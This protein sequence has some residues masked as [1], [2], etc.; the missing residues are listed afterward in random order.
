MKIMRVYSGADGQSHFDEIE[1]EI[2][3]LQPAEAHHSAT[4]RPTIST[5]GIGPPVASISS[6]YQ[7]K[8]RSRSVMAPSGNR[9]LAISISQTI[10]PVRATCREPSATSHASL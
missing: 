9:V 10:R 4:F 1:V 2:E 8:A 3:K 7:V 6:T 5:T